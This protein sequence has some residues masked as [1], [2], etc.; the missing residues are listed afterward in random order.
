MI[1]VGFGKSLN[2]KE[3]NA[4][5]GRYWPGMPNCILSI[6]PVWTSHQTVISASKDRFP[7]TNALRKKGRAFRL[8]RLSH[9]ETFCTDKVRKKVEDFMSSS[10]KFEQK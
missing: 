2:L 1:R 6:V 3:H 4:E 9:M 7:V 10:S 5:G 8:A